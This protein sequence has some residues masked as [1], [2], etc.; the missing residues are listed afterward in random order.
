MNPPL[1]PD[2]SKK[3]PSVQNSR[4]CLLKDDENNLLLGFL[5]RKCVVNLFFLKP[6]TLY[7]KY[8]LY[9]NLPKSPGDL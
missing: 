5:G 8:I 7:V 6:K 4:S 9:L 3:R 1:P 2:H